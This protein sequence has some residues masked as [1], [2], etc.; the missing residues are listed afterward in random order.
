MSSGARGLCQLSALRC[1]TEL[2]VPSGA[3]FPVLESASPRALG[4]VGET[5][6]RGHGQPTELS[7]HPGVSAE[8]AL[9]GA[10]SEVC[11]LERGFTFGSSLNQPLDTKFWGRVCVSVSFV[12]N[13]FVM[14]QRSRLSVVK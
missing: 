2:Q 8:T 7:W 13:P 12:L 11:R 6:S 5:V 3:F 4:P 1:T 14:V 9:L 10:L